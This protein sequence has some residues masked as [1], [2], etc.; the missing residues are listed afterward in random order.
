[1]R[2][3]ITKKSDLAVRALIALD[4]EG[5]MKGR[6]LAESVGTTAAFIA[7]VMNPLVRAGWVQ[8]DPGPRG[9]YALAVS[10]A[11]IS[12]LDLIEEIEGPTDD[13]ECVLR[14]GPCPGEQW[15]ALHEA[16]QPARQALLDRLGTT[17][18]SKAVGVKLEG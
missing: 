9:G 16:W 7:Q 10:L 17:P 4:R 12:M 14:G 13:G 1:M 5:R 6:R 2:L 18:I 3:E 15:C 11:Q 8:S